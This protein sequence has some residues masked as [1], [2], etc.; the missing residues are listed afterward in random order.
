MEFF[1]RAYDPCTSIGRLARGNRSVYP[2]SA[3]YYRSIELSAFLHLLRSN[4]LAIPLG[5]E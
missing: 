1:F 3:N 4:F 2:Q 5:N